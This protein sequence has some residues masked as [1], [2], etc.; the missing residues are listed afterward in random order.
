MGE[1]LFTEKKEPQKRGFQE[2]GK[3]AFHRQ[4]LANDAASRSRELR[5]VSA[6]LKF[7]GNARHNTE[8]KIDGEILP[9]KRATWL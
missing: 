3:H 6:E 4:W 9:Q 2:K 1:A 8:Q 7:H 5:P